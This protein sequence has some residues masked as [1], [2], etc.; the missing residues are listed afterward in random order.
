MLK[1]EKR[2]LRI[3]ILHVTIVEILFHLERWYNLPRGEAVEKLVILLSPE[4]IEVEKKEVVMEALYEYKNHTIDFVDIYLW[5][6]SKA[7]NAHILSFDHDFDSL[8][9]SIRIEP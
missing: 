7:N 1:A 2:Q 5:T 6:I 8:A 9:P 4:W 3:S